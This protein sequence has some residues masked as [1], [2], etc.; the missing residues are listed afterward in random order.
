MVMSG[1]AKE[2]DVLLELEDIHMYFGKVTALSNVNLKIRKGESVLI[3]IDSLGHFRLAEE[4]AKAAEPVAQT[5]MCPSCKKETRFYEGYG[6]WC[7]DCQK[8]AAK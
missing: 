2:G 3:T 6:H 5:V 8:Y 1:E 7:H 4:T